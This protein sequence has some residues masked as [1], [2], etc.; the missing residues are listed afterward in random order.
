MKL[1]LSHGPWPKSASFIL[2]AKNQE[3]QGLGTSS[4]SSMVSEPSLED[5]RMSKSNCKHMAF[6]SKLKV[7]RTLGP[8]KSKGQASL[9]KKVKGL[10][11]QF[12]DG[13][14]AA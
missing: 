12:A 3:G 2:V 10:L 7:L 9:E 5:A 4:Y 8:L 1:F 6:F 14:D 11:F 13:I